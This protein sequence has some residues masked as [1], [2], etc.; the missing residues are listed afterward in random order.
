MSEV[1]EPKNLVG[2]VR[3]KSPE[4][5]LATIHAWTGIKLNAAQLA[6]EAIDKSV[7]SAISFDAP[8]DAA[9]AL[10]ERGGDGFAPLTAFAIGVRSM[11]AARAAAKDLGAV[12]EIGPS[13]YKINLRHGKRKKD[14]PF[15]VLS[16]S[17]G[18]APA[19]FVCGERERDV[20]GL[21]A[22]MT[23]TLPKRDFGPSDLHFEVRV[24]P[25]VDTYSELINQGLH[26]GAALLP[27]KLQIGEPSFDRAI[28]RM[29][30]GLSDEIGA[31]AHDVDTLTF[32]LSMAPDKATTS[33]TLRLKGQT[34]WS[35]GNFASMAARSAPPPPMF[36]RLPAS[37]TAAL[38]QYPA[39]ARRF[40]AVRNTVGE[41]LD[42][43]LQHDGMAA[44]DRAALK[45]LLEE[46]FLVDAPVV[47]GLGAFA[48]ADAPAKPPAKPPAKGA[49]PPAND[50]LQAALAK[51]GW[52]LVGV[53]APNQVPEFWKAAATAAGRPKVQAYFKDKLA[54]LNSS[55][56]LD[57]YRAKQ[58]TGFTFKSAPVPKELPKGSLA[59]ELAVAHEAGP[60][61][62]PEKTAAA[63]KPKAPPSF[64]KVQLLVVP[65][66]SQTWIA[67]GGDK[68][69]LAKVV[70]AS[71]EGAPESG[72]LATRQDV[73]AFR[74]TKLAEGG[75]FTLETILSSFVAP[76]TWVDSS[77]A[78]DAQGAHSLLASAP[79]KGKTPIVTTEEIKTGDAMTVLIRT[80]IPKGVIEDAV[81][82]AA[83]SGLG[84]RSRP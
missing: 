20:D 63:R 74:Q 51:A 69:E 4:A 39:E 44:A 55:G 12:T 84:P 14:K 64:V 67:L 19:R 73:G 76:A 50:P 42:G 75:F 16:A 43:W 78:Q 66:N 29:A 31:I 48:A 52:L 58:M 46:K 7:A 47:A 61:E 17:V 80:E 70:L 5:T 40:E 23:R 11:D 57:K 36:W 54:S 62:A 45:A 68:A 38:Y 6:S 10:D 13:E 35:A 28:D 21:R 9:I 41:L 15:C 27:R 34:S 22:Y 81:L 2:I 53:G 49:A 33:T 1:A 8:V 79:N 65:E 83:T 71:L 82:L 56:E 3:W 60:A 25:V 72:T 26:M 59:F 37:S 18:A 77:V 30:A 32:D 24:A